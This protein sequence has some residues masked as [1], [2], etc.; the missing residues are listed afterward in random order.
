M[1]VIAGLAVVHLVQDGSQD[2]AV[3]L[4][5]LISYFL[6]KTVADG[7]GFNDNYRSVAGICYDSTVDDQS[8]RRCIYNNVIINISYHAD[9]ILEESVSEKLCRVRR[10]D[11]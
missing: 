1:T 11:R 9:H 8:K 4:G 5:K 10:Y 3:A 2:R 6:Y 7:T